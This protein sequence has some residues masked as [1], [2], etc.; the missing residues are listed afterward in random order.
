LT[1][2]AAGCAKLDW[3]GR[4]V[5]LQVELR[6]LPSGACT[7]ELLPQHRAVDLAMR[8]RAIVDA[9]AQHLQRFGIALDAASCKV[10]P[11]ALARRTYLYQLC[12]AMPAK[13]L[14]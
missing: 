11:A 5:R 1:E 9:A 8:D 4:I 12:R 7:F 10:Y 6:H 2:D 3:L 14:Q 13:T